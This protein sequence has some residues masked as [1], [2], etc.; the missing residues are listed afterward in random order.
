MPIHPIH[1]LNLLTPE[2]SSRCCCLPLYY[3][4]S[5]PLCIQRTRDPT[6][7]THSVPPVRDKRLLLQD[8]EHR[9]SFLT[10]VITTLSNTTVTL[11]DWADATAACQQPPAFVVQSCRPGVKQWHLPLR[12]ACSQGQS[13]AILASAGAYVADMGRYSSPNHV[14]VLLPTRFST[15]K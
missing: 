3:P 10:S 7:T 9:F 15:K 13:S 14:V 12:L 8:W 2:Q 5:S 11:T 1:V 6:R 4:A